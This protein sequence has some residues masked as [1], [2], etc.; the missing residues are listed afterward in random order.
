MKKRLSLYSPC[1]VLLYPALSPPPFWSV[2]PSA[3]KRYAYIHSSLSWEGQ[4]TSIRL[5]D[6][7]FICRYFVYSNYRINLMTLKLSVHNSFRSVW[8][9]ISASGKDLVSKLLTIDPIKR[10][11]QCP[12]QCSTIPRDTNLLRHYSILYWIML[13]Y[14]VLYC[15]ILHYNMIHHTS[16]CLPA[17]TLSN[18]SDTLCCVPFL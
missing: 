13:Y 10:S 7:P 1:P 5:N 16:L 15:A 12:S 14:T 6:D 3:K 11:A 8:K 9:K 17:N 4:T 2:T 18:I